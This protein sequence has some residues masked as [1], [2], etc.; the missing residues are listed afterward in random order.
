M[1]LMKP[2]LRKFALTAHVT[3][4]VGWLGAV[5]AYVALVIALLASQ[6]VQTV[7][8]T[9]LA[10][11]VILWFVIIPFSLGS[12][13]TGVVQSLG[14]TWG[15]FRHWWVIFKLG[16]TVVGILVLVQYTGSLNQLA[17]TAA[18][19]SL[20]GTDLDMLRNPTHL[21]HAGGGLLVL[22]VAQVL[23]MYK[24][25]GTTRFERRR[26]HQ[27]RMTRGR[28]MDGD[29]PPPEPDPLYGGRMR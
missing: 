3:T 24:P 19:G 7:R 22:L 16:L 21:V 28:L 26:Q 13:L 14:T 10:M 20:S 23:A 2:A 5:A 29:A 17:G 1:M 6:D 18:G 12:L 9:Y 8:A 11:K 15:L 25:R 4:T 27:Q